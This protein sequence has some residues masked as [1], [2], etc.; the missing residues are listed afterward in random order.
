MLITAFFLNSSQAPATGLSATI[1]ILESITGT[2]VANNLAMTEI[3]SGFYKYDF[4]SYDATKEYNFICFSNAVSGD[5]V[6][7]GG[8]VDETLINNLQ[9]D[10]D[11]IE[12]KIDTIDTN[13]DTIVSTTSSINSKVDIIDTNV[14]TVVTTTNSIN[15]KVDILDTNLDALIVDTT[16]IDVKIDG[17]QTLIEFIRDVEGGKWRI[18]ST[19]NQMI[20]Y[21]PDNTTEL[22]RFNLYDA[23]GTQS[24]NV[25]TERRRV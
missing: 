6:A 7:Y 10:T 11:S 1:T 8:T 24:S 2:V 14:D 4:T 22:M 17:I 3:S 9:I 5:K 16:A 25:I 19:L 15:S 23:N 20:F 13:V 18:D 21:K 12:T